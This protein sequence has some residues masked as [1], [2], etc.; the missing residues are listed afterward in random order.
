M[1][2]CNTAWCFA[3]LRCAELAW[4]GLWCADS[5]CNTCCTAYM[6][7][8]TYPRDPFCGGQGGTLLRQAIYQNI[9]AYGRM[10]A[11]LRCRGKLYTAVS[12][13]NPSDT[14]LL[15]PVPW[16]VTN[17]TSIEELA[18]LAAASSFL[19]CSMAGMAFTQLRGRPVLDGGFSAGYSH[20]CP[21]HAIKCIEVSALTVGPNNP[22]NAPPNCSVAPTP[23]S[24]KTQPEVGKPS[25][26][27]QKKVPPRAQ[28]K[29]PDTCTY[30]QQLGTILSPQLPSLTAPGE[31]DIY[32]GFQYN[33]LERDPCEWQAMQLN[34]EV[35]KLSWQGQVDSSA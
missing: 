27:L 29:L 28:W 24:F 31:P 33:R 19:P 30:D 21:P 35:R 7:Q 32:P 2:A 20:I 26:P 16:T 3:M 13:L 12:E 15:N 17:P 1:H 25:G 14:N 5:A 11:V 22:T 8:V 4:H 9:K 18:D 34:V 6:F 10:D 23:F